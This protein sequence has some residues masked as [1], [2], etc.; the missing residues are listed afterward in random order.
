M[1]G[2]DPAGHLPFNA[3][4]DVSSVV[5]R[6][7]LLSSPTNC[8]AAANPNKSVDAFTGDT[9]DHTDHTSNGDTLLVQRVSL[10]SGQGQRDKDSQYA[11]SILRLHPVENL[12]RK[13]SHCMAGLR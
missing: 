7:G 6:Q 12:N 2:P 10:R 1:L 8:E 11:R 3:D 13:I 4:N 9:R 5:G